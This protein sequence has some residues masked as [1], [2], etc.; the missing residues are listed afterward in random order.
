MDDMTE[1]GSQTGGSGKPG[2]GMGGPMWAMWICCLALL[3]FLI[4]SFLRR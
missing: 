2:R 4:L 3:L 1:P